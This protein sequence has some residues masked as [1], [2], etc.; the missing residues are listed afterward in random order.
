M[1]DPIN[2][3]SPS[4]QPSAY[5][6]SGVPATGKKTLSIVSMILGIVGVLLILTTWPAVLFGIAAV[7]TGHLAQRRE[8]VAGRGFWITGLITGYVAIVAGIIWLIV[9]IA[10]LAALNNGDFSTVPTN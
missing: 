1:T 2:D 3:S 6:Q 7:I 8:K 5:S 9:S 4:S 10:I